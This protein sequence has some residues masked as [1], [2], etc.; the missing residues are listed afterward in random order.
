MSQEFLAML[1][2]INETEDVNQLAIPL[3]DITLEN[4][5]LVRRNLKTIENTTRTLIL[6]MAIETLENLMLRTGELQVVREISIK[7]LTRVEKNIEKN[8]MIGLATTRLYLNAYNLIPIVV[9]IRETIT[10]DLNEI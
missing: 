1:D 3:M 9:S 4:L 8:H 7:I 2:R 10:P 6:A 5:R